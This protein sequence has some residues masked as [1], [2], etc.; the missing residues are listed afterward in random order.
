MSSIFF[1][2]LK[3]KDAISYTAVRAAIDG[4]ELVKGMIYSDIPLKEKSPKEFVTLADIKSERT[5]TERIRKVFPNHNISSEEIGEINVD[6]KS[7]WIIDPLDGT[8]N[9]VHKIPTYAVSIAYAEED[10]VKFGAIYVPASDDLY[11]AEL[12]KGAML[13]GFSIKASK[14]SRLDRSMIL[15]DNQYYSHPDM[16]KNYGKIVDNSFTTRITGSACCD[17]CYV[18]SGKAEARVMH[19]PKTCDFAAGAL[20]LTESGGRVTD[21]EGQLWSI[22]SKNI[23]AS[24]GLIHN[25][26]LNLFK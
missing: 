24:N 12:G 1:E 23:I 26:L 25:E 13:N 9:Y 6:G 2:R 20:I 22:K 14:E 19:S 5:I 10:I 4:G 18:A 16:L 11:T 3:M 8:H 7:L 17:F 21:F 15:C